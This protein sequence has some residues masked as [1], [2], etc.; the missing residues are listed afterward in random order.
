MYIICLT[1]K[2][3]RCSF[4]D[5]QNW[6][7]QIPEESI[8]ADAASPAAQTD[9]TDKRENESG[10]KR[11]PSTR[12]G[13]PPADVRTPR[14]VTGAVLPR[15]RGPTIE[16][17]SGGGTRLRG[18][19]GAHGCRPLWRARRGA[20]R[21]RPRSPGPRAAFSGRK[22]EKSAAR[23]VILAPLPPLPGSEFP[24]GERGKKGKEEEEGNH[25]AVA[26]PSNGKWVRGTTNA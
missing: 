19:S 4:P 20:S 22:A 8:S 5:Y 15:G 21:P 12:R 23:P 24:R 7:F 26:L 9:L 16:S 11:V 17:L 13:L 18:S 3:V 10:A 2:H 1:Q 6:L 25:Y 14:I